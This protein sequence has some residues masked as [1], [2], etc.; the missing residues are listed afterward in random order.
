MVKTGQ[1][2]PFGAG[3]LWFPV[4]R[5]GPM[6]GIKGGQPESWF[7]VMIWPPESGIFFLGFAIVVEP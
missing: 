4:P 7:T 5:K 6:V 2:R 1:Y 3:P